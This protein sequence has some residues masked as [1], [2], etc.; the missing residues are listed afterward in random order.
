[1]EFI[2]TKIVAFFTANLVSIIGIGGISGLL[3]WLIKKYFKQDTLSDKLDAWL[4]SNEFY[5]QCIGYAPGK[6]ISVWFVSLPFIGS[7]WNKLIEPIV[8]FFSDLLVKIGIW[9]IM[10]VVVGFKKGMMSDNPNYD[11]QS[12]TDAA[13]A[14]KMNKPK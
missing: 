2:F 14:N 10:N 4:I 7:V 11:G 13:L 1:M 6:I 12:A 5:V 8:I 3:G 9:F